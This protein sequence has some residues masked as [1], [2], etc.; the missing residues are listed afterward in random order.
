MFK[1]FRT[2]YAVKIAP[3]DDATGIEYL[4][5]SMSADG[6]ELYTMHEAQTES[7]KPC[8]NC[9]FS[10]EVEIIEEDFNTN[11]GDLDNPLEKMFRTAQEP[12]NLCLQFQRK[13]REKKNKIRKIKAS[14]EN[15]STEE[16]HAKL[17]LEIS[18]ELSEL[19]Q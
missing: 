12:Y 2:E 19:Q 17:N 7:G 10:R 1:D 18:R 8:Y 16:E 13:I 15:I 14:L 3:L 6:W 9:I 11:V 4:L 5:N